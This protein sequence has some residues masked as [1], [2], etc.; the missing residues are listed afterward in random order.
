MIRPLTSLRFFFAF[1]VFLSHLSFVKTNDI[2]Y[3][4]LKRNIFFE[5]Y[6]G[7]SFF[8]ILSGFVLSYSYKT[9]FQNHKITKKDFYIARFSR[10]YPLQFLTLLLAIPMI[11]FYSSFQI[12]PFLTNLFLVHSFIPKET[13][14]FSFNAPAWSISNEMFF[15]IIFPF[16]I[17]INNLKSIVYIL[18]PLLLILGIVLIPDDYHKTIFYVNPVIRS[19]DFI[20]GILLYCLFSRKK[21]VSHFSTVKKATI[22]EVLSVVIFLLFFIPHNI[23]I[24]GF[25]FSIYYWIPMCIIIY[26]F[27]QNKGLISKILSNKTLVFLGEISFGFYMIHYL[28]ISYGNILNEKY[29]FNINEILLCVIYFVITFMLSCLSF[30]Y[31][32]KP[33]NTFIKKKLIKQ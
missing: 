14:F 23:F 9:K 16:L 33:M 5:G 30:I 7:V 10:I 24:R 13:F 8:F 11:C 15:Y 18:I 17:L 2:F 19:L 6:V 26:T 1:F 27:A 3:N 21:F 29:T 32:E 22:L 31:Y 25:R 12:L 20:L 28:I 4:W